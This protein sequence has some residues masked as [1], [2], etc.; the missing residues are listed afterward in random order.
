[1]NESKRPESDLRRSVP[2]F[3]NQCVNGPDLFKVIVDD[4][5]AVAIEPNFE[6][7]T[8]HP[9]RGRVCPNAY[10][11]VQKT[12][13]PDRIKAPMRRTNPKKGL[14]QDPKW[15]EISWD[16]ALD[17]VAEKMLAARA[18]GLTD[19]NGHPRLA[20][21]F[22]EGGAPDAYYGSLNAL[23]QAWGGPIDFG[24]GTGE[25]IKC[26]HTEH[27]LGEFWHRAF[28]V[29]PDTPSTQLLLSFGHNDNV[30]SGVQGIFRHAEG[31]TRGMRRVQIE[32]HLSVTGAKADAWVPIRPKTDAAF[33]LAM[34]NVI[35]SESDWKSTCDVGFLQNMTNSPY[36]IGPKGHY[37]RD[38]KS[39][40]PLIWDNSSGT[41]KA[42]DDPDVKDPA[43][44]GTFKVDGVEVGPDGEELPCHGCLSRPSF[45]LMRDFVKPYS[46]EWAAKICDVD[47]DVIRRLASDFVKTASVGSTVEVDG[48]T[49]PFRPVSILLGKTV[50]NGWGAFQAVW[51]RTVLLA[52]VGALEVPGS[53]MG[54]NTRLNRPMSDRLE[55][56]SLGEDG[57]MRQSLNPTSKEGWESSPRTR[58]A[59]KTLVPLVLDS[60][61]SQAL[62]PSSLPYLF[63]TDEL[64]GFTRVSPPDV[65]IVF[66]ANPLISLWDVKPVAES[67]SKFPFIVAFA[68]VPDETNWFADVLLPE[69][70]DLESLQLA[71]IGGTSYQEQ[72][73]DYTG[74]A[75]RQPAVTPSHDTRDMTDIATELAFRLGLV[76]EYYK[77]IN[78]GALGFRL[79]TPHY[80]FSLHPGRKYTSAEMW[81]RACR[82][83]TLALSNGK[84][85]HDLDWFREHGFYVVPFKRIN[86]YL[87]PLMVA[88]KLRY[89]LPYQERLFRVGEELHR[90]LHEK[91]VSWW[92]RQL[93]EYQALP[94]WED[95]PA[96]WERVPASFGKKPQD[97]A[98]W[99]LTTKSMQFV[100]GLNAMI[101]MLIDV[102]GNIMGHRAVMMNAGVGRELKLKDNDWV[103]IQSPIGKVKGRVLLR[104]GVRPD[105]LVALGQFGHWV[106]PRAKDIGMP[107]M[108]RLVPITIDTTDGTGS[109]ADLVRVA[110]SK[111]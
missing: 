44:V 110:V 47:A 74:V 84:E 18:K 42:Y 26:Y 12:Y 53:V 39:K 78:R 65:W 102:S 16:E 70:T 33:L 57:F 88:K 51:A 31:R 56:V 111:A 43:L 96:I 52:L 97:Y 45:D 30:T 21:V 62:G 66:R 36:L 35:I 58:N 49:L 64:E 11:L 25:G 105:V 50:S 22:G 28:I 75:I 1:M 82:A 19:E 89:E 32:P 48:I 90:R 109:G 94:G 55:T 73:W 15:Q 3:C 17:L 100:H 101:P 63:V 60:S 98:F 67:L 87:H 59:Y 72:Y 14:D 10:G 107:G 54:V 29:A 81:D 85:E 104:E 91:G 86:W 68:Y 108:N 40:K 27:L 37:L 99:L 7:S 8:V 103:W 24:F 23:L 71:R 13:N 5:R 2:T 79:R 41:P 38:A 9:A 20:A 4:G 92:D 77:S 93:E 6:A 46:P 106:T 80:D 61:W 69:S 76:E 34:L 83:A 95:F